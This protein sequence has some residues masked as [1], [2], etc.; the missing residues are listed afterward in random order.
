[1]TMAQAEEQLAEGESSSQIIS[2]RSETPEQPPEEGGVVGPAMR[3]KRRKKKDPRPESIIVFR[4][5][6]ERTGGEDP[7]A[8]EGPER[9]AEEAAKFLCTPTSD[10]KTKK[11]ERLRYKLF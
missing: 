9:S 8:E 10:G 7:G 3:R 4:S 1:M 11:T 2:L 5:E 6:S